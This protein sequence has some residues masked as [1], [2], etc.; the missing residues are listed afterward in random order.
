M[1][2]F[3]IPASAFIS[4]EVAGLLNQVV[5]LMPNWKWLGL[6]TVILVGLLLRPLLRMALGHL[7]SHN[8]LRQRYPNGFI[9]HLFNY[10]IE[11]QVA[12]LSVLLFWTA[13]GSALGLPG[14]FATFY[15]HLM[16]AFIALQI[17]I[18]LY[19]A[20]DAM[21]EVF[22]KIAAN[23]SASH[24]FS[25]QLIPYASKTI[26]IFI[27]VFG[28][29]IALQSFGLN[30]VSLLA[31]LGLG[32]LALALA[33]QD[34]AANV[35]GSITIMCD[36]PFKVGDWIKMKDTEGTVE[37]IGFRSTRVRTFYNS[38]I[39]V[40]NAMIAK[41]VV[42]NL[43]IRPARR[44]RQVLGITYET[45]PEK[46]IQFCDRVRAMITAQP[47]VL[48]ETVTVN[49]NNYADSALNI[50]VNFHLTIFTTDEELT[51]QQNIFIEILKIAAELKVDFAY[52]TQT[53]YHKEMTSSPLHHKG[54][55]TI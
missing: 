39:T 4:A 37:E 21:T 48:P 27:V 5:F 38:V 10:P 41:E 55:N 34:T 50:L 31:G 14:K 18:L 52:P 1:D 15:E 26:K 28:V 40:P 33:A 46:I 20:V 19:H 17:I 22:L 2:K 32:G 6:V 7:K 43:G 13:M 3:I 53:V 30:V 25:G 11:K 24:N 42:D 44:I 29:L 47:E 45:P 16:Q 51:A 49:F 12:W 35:F 23:T 9:S 54:Q 36:N 8:P